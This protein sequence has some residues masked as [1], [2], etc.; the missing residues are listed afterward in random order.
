LDKKG[1]A[2]LQAL[3]QQHLGQGGSIVLTT[4][5]TLDAMPN[6]KRLGL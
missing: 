3:F 1:I 4:H 6:I 5:Q 2:H